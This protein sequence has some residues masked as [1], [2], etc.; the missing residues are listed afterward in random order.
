MTLSGIT[1]ALRTAFSQVYATTAVHGTVATGHYA[2]IAYAVG[3]WVE[4]GLTPEIILS[5]AV[6]ATCAFVTYRVI[7][8]FKNEKKEPEDEE[9]KTD[10]KY[11]IFDKRRYKYILRDNNNS[12]IFEFFQ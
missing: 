2:N 7:K 6:G 3:N 12:N 11:D 9:A 1:Y 4:A 10:Y 5:V 8:Y